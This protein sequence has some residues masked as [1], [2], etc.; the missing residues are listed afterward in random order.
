MPL[1]ALSLGRH[2]SDSASLSCARRPDPRVACAASWQRRRLTSA[3]VRP[4]GRAGAEQRH[5]L[6]SPAGRPHCSR[7]R[8]HSR[9]RAKLRRGC[10]GAPPRGQRGQSGR[11][12]SWSLR[13]FR[14]RRGEAASTPDATPL[15]KTLLARR[16]RPGQCPPATWL[17]RP[18]LPVLGAHKLSQ[19]LAQLGPRSSLE[20]TRAAPRRA[21]LQRCSTAR[22]A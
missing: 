14:A 2:V 11:M 17:T 6:R 1:A 7:G 19:A 12:R 3:R 20:L 13:F 10:P 21:P 16:R 22:E 5:G 4:R 18:R 8:T 9:R 15:A